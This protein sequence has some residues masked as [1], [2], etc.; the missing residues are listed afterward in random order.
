MKNQNRCVYSGEVTTN[1]KVILEKYVVEY[2]KK[3]N[4]AVSNKPL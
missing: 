3:L 1:K 2:L 4:Y